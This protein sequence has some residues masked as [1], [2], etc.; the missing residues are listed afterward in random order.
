MTV[1]S[2]IKQLREKLELTQVGF[3]KRLGV[4]GPSVAQWETNRTKPKPALM[5][6]IARL[7]NVSLRWLMDGVQVVEE[8]EDFAPEPEGFTLMESGGDETLDTNFLMECQRAVTELCRE[9]G[10]APTWTITEVV[11]AVYTDAA[12]G[13][14][15]GNEKLKNMEAVLRVYRRH[16]ELLSGS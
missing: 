10:I 11:R 1:G 12:A 4:T 13:A 9:L 2:R 3:G 8:C 15:T 7:G 16:P 14:R 6:D 5:R